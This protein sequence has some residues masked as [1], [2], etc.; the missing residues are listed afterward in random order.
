MS[1]AW[2]IASWKCSLVNDNWES[3]KIKHK[4]NFKDCVMTKL[5]FLNIDINTWVELTDWN[6]IW[7]DEH[8]KKCCECYTQALFCEKVASG[9]NV[10]AGYVNNAKSHANP[11]K[12]AVYIN[13][14]SQRP[15]DITF[16]QHHNQ[17]VSWYTKRLFHKLIWSR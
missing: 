7:L 12:L 13:I 10:W 2:M 9:R 4:K 14:L 1:C 17:N 16:S 5:K 11:W 3:S 6:S 15:E 8:W